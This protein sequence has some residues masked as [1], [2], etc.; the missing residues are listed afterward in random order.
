MRKL[1]VPQSLQR[2][3]QRRSLKNLSEIQNEDDL[4]FQAKPGKLASLP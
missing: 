3:Q 1:R 4:L 2:K